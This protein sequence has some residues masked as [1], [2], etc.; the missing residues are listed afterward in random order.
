MKFWKSQRMSL[1]LAK[2]FNKKG[3]IVSTLSPKRLMHAILKTACHCARVDFIHV[4]SKRLKTWVK[5]K[6]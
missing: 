5:F 4:A 3:N 2:I 1:F 6:V